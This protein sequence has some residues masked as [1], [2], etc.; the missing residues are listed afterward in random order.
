MWAA[1]MQQQWDQAADYAE[2]LF[3]AS[4]WSKTSYL[5]L[6]AVFRYAHYVDTDPSRQ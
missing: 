2:R 6:L 5:Y 1:A 4:N 3:G